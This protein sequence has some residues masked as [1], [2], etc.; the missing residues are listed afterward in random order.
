M[1]KATNP[2]GNGWTGTARLGDLYVGRDSETVERGSGGSAV[3]TR[4]V[5]VC[6]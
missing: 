4:D 5:A 3:S 1:S 6:R 2:A